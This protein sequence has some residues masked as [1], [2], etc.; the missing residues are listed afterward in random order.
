MLRE[1]KFNQAI[2]EA[3]EQLLE[4]DPSVY[5]MGLGVPD[6]KG[7]FGTTSGL[8]EKF[9]AKR[10]MDMPTSENGM[11]GIAIGT[12]LLGMRP[13]MVHQRVD[14]FILALDQLINNGAKWHYMFGGQMNVPLVIRLIMGRGW[15]QGP[16]H[17]Q[18]LQSIFAHIPGLKV[19]MP[20]TPYDAKGL[21]IAATRDNNPVV[22]LEHRWLHDTYG[23]VPEEMYEVPIGK[24]KIIKEGSDIT[25]VSLSH[26][27]IEARKAVDILEKENISVELIDL[28]TVKPYDKEIIIKSVRKT[29]RLLVADPDWKTCGF[30]A[31]VIAM[32]SEESLGDL[33]V[34]PARV[35]YPDRHSPTSW[36]LAN[37]FYP[38]AQ[39][40]A[41][42]ALRMT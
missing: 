38:N 32:I 39:V 29:G 25:I 8:Q 1:L 11:T 30:A 21:L 9:G 14:F 35:T 22:F 31:E 6:P 42:H 18:S 28:R 20:S 36:S 41:M 26:M 34:A 3:G 27:T 10:V 23:F 7:V 12:A 4:S 19:V 16:Q 2:L 37:H 15:G 24:G 40:I 17:S 13:I 5:L 33:K